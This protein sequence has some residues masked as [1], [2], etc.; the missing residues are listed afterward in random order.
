MPITERTLKMWRKGALEQ[1]RYMRSMQGD[2][3]EVKRREEE[4]KRILRMSQELLDAHL[5]QKK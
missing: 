4:Q 3:R 2:P 1:L 5:L